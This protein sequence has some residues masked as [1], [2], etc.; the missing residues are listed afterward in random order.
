MSSHFRRRE[1]L[2]LAGVA[3]IAP[4]LMGAEKPVRVGLVGV[5]NR[6][7]GLVKIL[8]D[9]PGA[10]IPAICDINEEHL[11]NPDIR[12]REQQRCGEALAAE[13]R[14]QVCGNH[15][16]PALGLVGAHLAGHRSYTI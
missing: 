15:R 7:T 11:Q 3:G 6:G 9:V 4:S 16:R 2:K 13:A 14:C 10:E 12:L 1:F 8:L 5:G